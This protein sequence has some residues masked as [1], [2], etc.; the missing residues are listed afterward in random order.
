MN[1][2]Q[3]Q[4]IARKKKLKQVR[5]SRVVY[6]RSQP[7]FPRR[8]QQHRDVSAKRQ[9]LRYLP[10]L[11]QLQSPHR[12]LAN[13]N[14]GFRVCLNRRD[15]LPPAHRR[16]FSARNWGGAA[17]GPAA[18]QRSNI[19]RDACAEPALSQAVCTIASTLKRCQ[20]LRLSGLAAGRLA[21]KAL[22]QRWQQRRQSLLMIRVGID[23][24]GWR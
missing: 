22:Q 9:Q 17:G 16:E 11:L 13:S 4:N 14:S 19:Y 7:N 5:C 6:P 18:L 2:L 23:L 10:V 20:P 3:H 8:L 21:T 12:R 1:L 24:S 15:R